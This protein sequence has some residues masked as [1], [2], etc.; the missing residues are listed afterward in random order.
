MRKLVLPLVLLI[1]AA[2]VIFAGVYIWREVNPRKNMTVTVQT[3]TD[4]VSTIAYIVKNEA[5]VDLSG[6]EYVRY[7][8]EEGDRVASN[9]RIAMVYDAGEDGRILEEID[10]LN[11]KISLFDNG[12]ANLSLRDAG[13]IEKFIDSYSEEYF[14]AVKGGRISEARLAKEN[15]V[16]LMNIKHSGTNLSE[17]EERKLKKE[18]EALETKLSSGRSPVKSPI[19]GVFSADI[20]GYEG[21]VSFDKAKSI[22][23]SEFDSV[24]EKEI[25]QEGKKCKVVDNY[26]WLLMC[27][28]PTDYGAKTQVGKKTEIVTDSGEHIDGT[29]VYISEP[30]NGNC[31]ITIS[32][33]KDFSSIGNVRKAEVTVT[34]NKYTGYII[35]SEAVHIYQDKEGVFV[36]SGNKLKFKE[37]EII[38]RNSNHTVI[39][40][41][42]KTELK[43]YDVVVV[44]G[45]LSEFYN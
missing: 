26:N 15:I 34:F 45:D 43:T 7:Y 24:M 6:G 33:N 23:V 20:D 22:T 1:I 19:G 42:E 39:K 14:E 8:C 11:E 4:S 30:D 36:K 35:P 27:K 41:S 13:K 40:P 18:K 21:L 10:A 3:M 17:S 2:T 31:I 32:S 38:Y 16:N 12:Y 9:S 29:V 5:V 37:T 28:V 25:S 44:E